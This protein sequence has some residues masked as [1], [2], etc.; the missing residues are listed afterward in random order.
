MTLTAN[1]IMSTLKDSTTEA[2]ARAERHPLQASMIRGEISP[3]AFSSYL[4]Q[5][6]FLHGALEQALTLAGARDARVPS[7]YR[8]DHDRT[9]QLDEDLVHYGIDLSAHSPTD[10]TRLLCE[11]VVQTGDR[12][13]VTTLGGLY[14]LEG[15]M[16]GGR[17]I[18]RAIC[19]A[20]RLA[21]G[22]AGTRSLDPYG[23]DQPRV[24]GEFRA[25]MDSLTLDEHE[26][27]Q[28]VLAAHALFDGLTSVME[29]LLE[30][31]EY[32]Q[33]A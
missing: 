5:L 32:A 29:A 28:I 14:V 3:E 4:V 25:N 33:T 8:D 12:C 27:E 6:R 18:A 20:F 23:D 17:F 16:N 13:P 11:S 31:P 22:T 15:S 2:H 9:V 21:P 24:W 7:V 1:S 30:N 26:R 10:A 19:K